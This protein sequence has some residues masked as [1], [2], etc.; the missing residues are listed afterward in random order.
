MNPIGAM[1]PLEAL[2]TNH[3]GGRMPHAVKP[4]G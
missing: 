2:N 3:N 1:K 4:S